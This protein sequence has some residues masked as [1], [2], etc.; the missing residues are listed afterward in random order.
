[1][2]KNLVLYSFFV[3]LLGACSKDHGDNNN[4]S[5][6][7]TFAGTTYKALTV[8]Y[9]NGGAQANLSA[10][11]SGGTTTSADG[12]SFVFSTPP[13]ISSQMLITYSGE[14]NTVLVTASKLSGTNTTFYLNEETNVKAD[15]T[16]NNGKVSVNFPGTIWLHNL[17]NSA[18]S[19]QLSV[20]TIT[21][22]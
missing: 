10:S 12:L 9:V 15:V 2:K 1:M 7:W 16:V 18:D 4:S 5:N 17:T 8:V 21:Q 3:L 11:A 14:P 6:T 20:G 19:A 22:Q 13:T